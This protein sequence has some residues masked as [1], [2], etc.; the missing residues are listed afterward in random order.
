METR[1]QALPHAPR[2]CP[3]L[4][5]LLAVVV[6]LVVCGSGDIAFRGF[7]LFCK[8][9]GTR[10]DAMASTGKDPNSWPFVAHSPPSLPLIPVAMRTE[11]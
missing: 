2:R 5:L 3:V 1:D 11:A 4:L 9:A 8:Q 7:S 6:V 10:I